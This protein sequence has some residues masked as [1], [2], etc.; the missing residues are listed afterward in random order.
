[1][2]IDTTDLDRSSNTS[3]RVRSEYWTEDCCEVA[4][5]AEDISGEEDDEDAIADGEAK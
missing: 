5:G 3:S 1:M 4:G 2:I